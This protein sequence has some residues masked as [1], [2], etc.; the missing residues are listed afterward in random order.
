MEHLV[1][2]AYPAFAFQPAVAADQRHTPALQ[3]RDL[4]GVVETAG[5]RHQS[6]ASA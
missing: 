4:P 1:A 2:D 3:P 5:V 6:V